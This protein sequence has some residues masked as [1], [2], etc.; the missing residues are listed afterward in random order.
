MHWHVVACA[1][2]HRHVIACTLVHWCKMLRHRHDY[3]VTH[4]HMFG[5]HRCSIC[6]VTGVVCRGMVRVYMCTGATQIYDL[7]RCRQR[8]A[9]TTL[10]RQA[11]R[12]C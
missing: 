4:R 6:T 7:V 3:C 1:P 5:M 2:V 9:V 8:H 11:D 10:P 12:M